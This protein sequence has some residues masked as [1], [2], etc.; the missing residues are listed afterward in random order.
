MSFA[1]IQVEL[2]RA[3][4]PSLRPDHD[5][6]IERY[7]D[8]RAAG[9]PADALNLYD[10]RLRGRYPDDDF[11]ERVLRAYRLRDPILAALLSSAYARLGE[12]LLERV[13]RTIKYVALK[14]GS[15]DPSDA[16]ST[17]KAA[18]AI[19]AMLPRERFEAIAAVE[20]LRRY[21]D[22][23][24]YCRPAMA[25]AE[26]LVRAY[27]TESLDVV[28]GERRRRKAEREKQE[29]ERREILVARDR[30]SIG[31]D[32][33]ARN[34]RME[35][36]RSRAF[37]RRTAE[38]RAAR[39]RPSATA[40][41]DLSRI[42]FSAADLS[43]IQIPPVLTGVEDRTLAFCFKYWNAVGD[44]AFE[45]VLFL[46]SRKFGTTHYDVFQL[47]RQGRR[48]GRRDEEILTAVSSR[49]ITGYYY[50]IRGDLYLQRA[51]TRLKARL[52][53]T[54][55]VPSSAP[56]AQ[57][58]L[59]VPTIAEGP[60]HP[61]IAKPR[62]RIRRATPGL[63]GRAAPGLPAIS[64]PR[65]PSMPPAARP[66]APPSPA[67]RPVAPPSVT[68]RRAI[69][70]PPEP[71]RAVPQRAITSGSVSDRLRKLSGRSYD[72]YEQRFLSKVR[73]AIRRVLAK[74]R[75]ASRAFFV[76]IPQ[77]A[78]DALFAFLRDH[79]SDP[80]MDW[81]GSEQRGRLAE[82]GFE[83]DSVDEIIKDCFARL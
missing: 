3:E 26:D 49:L 46:Y 81:N 53:G 57:S 65:T 30:A 35:R 40:L 61:A 7:F 34:S 12:R 22:L 43:R 6:D 60:A 48:S 17:I 36:E 74:S 19:L 80:Y 56:S 33:V 41:M 32:A 20:R 54:P 31:E 78:E 24:E 69:A 76:T 39:S 70:T 68:P 62:Q 21:A 66:H 42:R 2:L 52:E 4:Y 16:Y 38:R 29:E 47:I 44:A 23:L 63:P 58:V 10:S 82:L 5:P 14:A 72:V 71:V 25:V 18:E 83:L 75:G 15:F 55:S 59:A 28:E 64:A 73:Q 9:R 13:K 67:P 8:M 37:E 11:R 45:R 27:L 77:E 1:E 50:S 79:Y 51:W